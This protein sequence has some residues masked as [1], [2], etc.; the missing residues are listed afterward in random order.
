MNN[1]LIVLEESFELKKIN[2]TNMD[3][4]TRLSNLPRIRFYVQIL[5]QNP[6]SPIYCLRRGPLIG[7]RN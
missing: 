4:Y 3:T 2:Q 6:S 1:S 7:I 5:N